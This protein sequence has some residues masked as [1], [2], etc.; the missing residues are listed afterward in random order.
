MQQQTDQDL[1]KVF[2]SFSNFSSCSSSRIGEPVNAERQRSRGQVKQKG[3]SV[4]MKQS[5][6]EFGSEVNEFG[7]ELVKSGNES[8]IG[9]SCESGSKSMVGRLQVWDGR[10]A[11]L[12][13]MMR[14]CGAWVREAKHR[15]SQAGCRNE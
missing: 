13:P 12:E 9:R 14:E 2:S 8:T 4:Q 11:I 10:C 1:W 3:S 5:H 7:N 15:T 6:A